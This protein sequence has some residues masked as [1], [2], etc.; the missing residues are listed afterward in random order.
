MKC[1][2]MMA[3][4]FASNEK[5]TWGDVNCIEE[6]CAWWDRQGDMCSLLC[7]G[8][9]LTFILARL[10]GIEDKMPHKPGL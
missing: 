6:E 7:Q 2:L 1:P 9:A 8:R 10:A 5:H 4:G 3:G